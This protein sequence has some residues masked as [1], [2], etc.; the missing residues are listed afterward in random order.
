MV[1]TASLAIPAPTVG[2][3]NRFQPPTVHAK[4]MA[5]VLELGNGRNPDF[6]AG[7]LRPGYVATEAGSLATRQRQPLGERAF[8]LQHAILAQVIQMVVG[9]GNA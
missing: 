1:R 4:L 8:V 7:R 5:L 3:A 2:A 9:C 6:A